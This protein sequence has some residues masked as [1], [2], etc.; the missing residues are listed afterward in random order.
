MYRS[1][2]VPAA[3]AV[4]LCA[5]AG[6]CADVGRAVRKVTYP[7]D[8]RYIPK[9]QVG[10]AMW[11]MATAVRKLDV[12]LRDETLAEPAKQQRVIAL[13]DRIRVTS[14]RLDG[15]PRETNHPLLDHK[16]PRLAADIQA[17]RIAASGTPPRYSLA[18]SVSGACIYCHLSPVPGERTESPPD[19]AEQ[20]GR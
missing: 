14:D 2:L 7:P 20:P 18:G 3:V 17:A 4:L 6:G 5:V 15:G 9:D 1:R 8:F 12:V 10:S 19:R 11:Q 16:V 13:L